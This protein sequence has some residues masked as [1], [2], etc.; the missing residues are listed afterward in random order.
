MSTTSTKSIRAVAGIGPLLFFSIATIEGFLR[1]DYDPLAQPIS[2]LAMGERGWIQGVNFL[3][4]AVSFLAM[5]AVL[6]SALRLGFA[7]LA[8][9]VVFT[10]M[11]IGVAVAGLFPMDPPGAAPTRSGELHMVGGFLV[12]P[13]IPVV[14]FLLAV[15]FRRDAHWRSF[16]LYSLVTGLFCLAALGFFLTFVGPPGFQR[17]FPGLVGVVQRLVLFPFF[18]WIGLV[19]HHA[20]ATVSTIS[21]G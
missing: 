1:S 21:D 6:R 4:L 2:A 11:A 5:A 18:I 20:R 12:F 9:P 3:L 16:F 19:V 14:V 13:L 7:S 15:R 8:A 17:P 10:I